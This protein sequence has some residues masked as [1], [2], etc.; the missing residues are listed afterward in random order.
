MNDAQKAVTLFFYI[1]LCTII[2]FGIRDTIMEYKR[3]Q[4]LIENM[5][6]QDKFIVL[7]EESCI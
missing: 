1:A 2:F 4:L 3:K 7:P 5:E 6:L